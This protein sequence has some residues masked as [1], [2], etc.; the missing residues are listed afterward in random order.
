MSTATTAPDPVAFPK[1]TGKKSKRKVPT[2][3]RK[4]REATE[5]GELSREGSGK[6]GHVS[7]PIDKAVRNAQVRMTVMIIFFVIHEK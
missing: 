5:E 3:L 7:S 6:M 1:K 4:A 2:L